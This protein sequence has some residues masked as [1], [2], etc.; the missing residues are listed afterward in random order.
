MDVQTRSLSSSIVEFFR[1]PVEKSVVHYD[2]HEACEKR[3]QINEDM[4]NDVNTSDNGLA[5]GLRGDIFLP[6]GQ[7]S[8][9]LY[10]TDSHLRPPVL[11]ILPIQRLRLLRQK[12]ELRRRRT[13]N[14]LR[15]VG[16]PELSLLDA[17][18]QQSSSTPS[19]VK[20]IAAK[21]AVKALPIL[22]SRK[23]VNNQRQGT[24]WSGE[25]DYDL[26]EYDN[27]KKEGK[28]VAIVSEKNSIDS[29][30]IAVS[31]PPAAPGAFFKD[32]NANSLSA[33]QRDVLLKGQPTAIDKQP[34]EKKVVTVP[35][36]S[37]IGDKS[38]RQD[39]EKTVLP[40]VGFDFIKPDDTP[41]KTGDLQSMKFG[42]TAEKAEVAPF[43]LKSATQPS[44]NFTAS[45]TDNSVPR[46]RDEEEDTEEPR[47]KK[48][49]GLFNNAIAPSGLAPEPSKSSKPMFSFGKGATG[50]T[51]G[52]DK[53]GTDKNPL[54]TSKPPFSF[55]KSNENKEVEKSTVPSFSFGTKQIDEVQ[56]KGPGLL[57]SSAT[58][59]TKPSF[60]FGTGPGLASQTT[61]ANEKTAEVTNNGAS[62]IGKDKAIASEPR[63]ALSFSFSG[64]GKAA[65]GG[66][67]S[68]SF[69]QGATNEKK[70]SSAPP[71]F[72]FGQGT[73]SSLKDKP[74]TPSFSFSG[75]PEKKDQPAVA[76]SAP[77]F[78]FGNNSL[79]DKKDRP[80][81]APSFSFGSGSASEKEKSTTTPSLT[82]GAAPDK[83]EPSTG[84]SFS[85][86]AG[87]ASDKNNQPAASF[88]FGSGTANEK[89]DQPHAAPSFSFSNGASEKKEQLAAAP[90]FSFGSG[91]SGAP[92]PASSLPPTNGFA[93]NKVEK[94]TEGNT[95]KPSFS[96]GGSDAT[97]SGTPTFGGAAQSNTASGPSNSSFTFN[98]PTS[99]AP[100]NNAIPNLPG[101]DAKPATSS[102]GFKFGSGDNNKA[103]PAIAAPVA[104][105]FLGGSQNNSGFSFNMSG[106]TNGSAPPSFSQAQPA[107]TAFG[108]TPSP[109]FGK[110]ASPPVVNGS[111]SSSRAFTPS[112]TINLN[113]GNNTSANP[114]SIFS[115]NP[116]VPSIG[117]GGPQQVFG[118][119]PPP[120][121]VFGAGSQP[122]GQFNNAQAG[123][124]ASNGI[125]AG[126]L[127]QP[128]QEAPV[129]NFQLP[130]GRKLARM[131]QSRR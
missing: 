68:F 89:K 52:I 131:R 19:P 24:K 64:S 5:S 115:G 114:S 96:F 117:T 124:G 62:E 56:T 26:S 13:L 17:G 30:T 37:H 40:S 66:K 92:K 119:T 25:F 21:E 73:A 94:A 7:G 3:E 29:P 84:P 130:P 107:Q 34:V 98:R 90:S 125:A 126:Q 16:A 102:F 31:K 54:L 38:L 108:T 28:S 88:T 104:N 59:S 109:A 27:H 12:Q 76:A 91:N 45:K 67:P 18:Y 22:K 75:A 71:A 78:S 35:G 39:E 23:V 128:V 58:S 69:G 97:K 123:F 83:R 79:S 9:I 63:P 100:S 61:S 41:S 70:D 44:F 122:T 4:R 113:F 14:V 20:A 81:V 101:P 42:K 85:F 118:G 72:S 55:N 8:L 93:F 105:P 10:E 11:P 103:A 80:A 95:Q 49:T 2:E 116:A 121:Q 74:P 1:K 111:N 46:S 32:I 48:P 60:S 36:I 43:Q 33:A 57:G 86:G 127:A 53:L 65:D 120:T 129:P 87:A 110:S 99:L 47:R 77:S 6:D 112:N 15:S 50:N 106:N 82:F 51:E